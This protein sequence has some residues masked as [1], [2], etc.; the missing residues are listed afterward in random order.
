MIV[1][2]K[3]TN[4]PGIMWRE[5]KAGER[6]YVV[7][8]RDENSKQRQ[9]RVK[10]DLQDAQRTLANIKAEQARGA[11]TSPQKVTLGQM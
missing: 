10:G 2:Y 4:Y 8:F 9:K 6:Q 7:R 11:P 5:G 3:R 1:N